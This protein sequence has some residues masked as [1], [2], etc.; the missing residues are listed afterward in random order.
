MHASVQGAESQA[1]QAHGAPGVQTPA[2]FSSQETYQAET[3]F[4]R[5]SQPRVP[6]N[7]KCRSRWPRMNCAWC[8]PV[9]GVGPVASPSLSLC[10]HTAFPLAPHVPGLHLPSHFFLPKGKFLADPK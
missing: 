8:I 3:V 6:D 7:T 5:G 1:A 4:C 9:R 2:R 10:F